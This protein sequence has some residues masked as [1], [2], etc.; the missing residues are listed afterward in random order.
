VR[1]GKR[2]AER[3]GDMEP[4][5]E[6]KA[7]CKSK[8]LWSLRPVRRSAPSATSAPACDAAPRSETPRA[9]WPHS[10]Q[11][12]LPRNALKPRCSRVQGVGGGGG[13][14]IRSISPDDVEQLWGTLAVV[15]EDRLYVTCWTCLLEVQRNVLR[16]RYR[17]TGLQ[18]PRPPHIQVCVF[19]GSPNQVLKAI[20]APVVNLLDE[21]GIVQRVRLELRKSKCGGTSPLHQHTRHHDGRCKVVR[22]NRVRCPPGL[23]HTKTYALI[24]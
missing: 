22:L 1:C 15:P 3:P 16:R 9:G 12:S 11:S 5:A 7:G 2:H 19:N 23:L 14:R 4:D 21:G 8:P 18:E 13:V 17:F 24:T 6:P 10:R 20:D